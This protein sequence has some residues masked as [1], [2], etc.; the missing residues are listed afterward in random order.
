[1]RLLGPHFLIA[2]VTLTVE[3]RMAG[4]HGKRL[5]IL[6]A[7]YPL[8][9]AEEPQIPRKQIVL[10]FIVN[11]EM[12]R[13]ATRLLRVSI[14][15]PFLVGRCRLLHGR[16][17]LCAFLLS[18]SSSDFKQGALGLNLG[19]MYYE[20]RTHSFWD[21]IKSPESSFSIMCLHLGEAN[22]HVIG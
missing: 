10:S 14:V 15:T 6:P 7:Q 18:V 20:P 21:L 16:G 13:L 19:G 2:Y 22:D 3:V 8:P 12:K 1:M 4:G 11:S 17:R 9:I 5:W